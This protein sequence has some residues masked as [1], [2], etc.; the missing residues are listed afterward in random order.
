M[1]PSLRR[2]LVCLAAICALTAAA[3]LG[4][5]APRV[6]VIDMLD[7][8]T[9]GRFDSVLDDL[10][11]LDRDFADILNQLNEHAPAWIEASGPAARDKRRLVAATFALE[12]ARVD[13]W[14]EWKWI[15][16][17]PAMCPA[18]I[19]GERATRGDC[20]YPLNV[21]TWQAPPRLIEWACQ[22]MGQDGAP[23]AVERWWHIAAIAVAQRSEDIQFLVGDP[24]IGRGRGA[25]EIINL[26]D[27]IK[28]LEHAER[29]FPD[30]VRFK[31]AQGIARERVWPADAA[32]AFE[33]LA[34]DYTVGGEAMARLAILQLR[35]GRVADALKSVDR[36]DQYTRDPYVLYLSAYVRGRIAEA[37][38]QPERARAAYER[39]VKVWPHGQAATMALASLLFQ[40]GR[41]AEAQEL[42]GGMLAASPAPPDPWREYVHGDDRFWPELVG[43]LR[44]E[45]RR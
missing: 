6:S 44:A 9:A 10:S 8:Y 45:I 3:S 32:Q 38:K 12:A 15:V 34:G 37:Q 33:A 7:R 19:P 14:H 17:Q 36:A 24:A 42:T 1:R 40:Q 43:K 22:L 23:A 13:A 31:L 35:L 29:R 16:R 39:A 41:R 28:H 27:E 21:L 25:G 2:T 11:T 18:H 4:A 5:R 20:Y 30:E 26:Q